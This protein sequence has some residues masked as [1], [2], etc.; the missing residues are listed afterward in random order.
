[1]V[2]YT[3]DIGGSTTMLIRDTGGNVEFWIKTGSQTWNNEQPWSFFANG[4]NSGTLYFRMLRG[5]NWQKFGEVH[6]SYDQDVRFTIFNAGLGFPTYDFWQH[7]SRS[8]VPGA[9][10]IHLTHAISSTYIQVGF[11]DGY[12]G[13]SPILE[14]RL[15]YGGNPNNLEA[16]WDAP[17]GLTNVGPFSPGSRVYFWAQERNAIGWSSWSNRTEAT[18]WRIPDAPA[19]I[20]FSDVTQTSVRTQFSDGFNGGT[21][22]LERELGYGEDPFNAEAFAND[23]S[24]I[25]VLTN[26][27]PGRTYY[28]WARTRNIVGWSAWSERR[29]INLIAG[30][31][32]FV[33][34]Q[35]VRAV[36]YVKVSGTWRVARPWVRNAGV[37]KETSV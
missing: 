29:Q 15:G 12:S 33:G 32:I 11:S 8:T 37:W 6:V 34:N 24:G 20:T 17:S 35:W 4:S 18:T 23:I 9:P 31:R 7:I 36:P 27:D 14:R 3:R 16:Y 2:D 10:Y 30:A 25:N 13:G 22:V 1:M 21:E 28:F 5:G 26:L 19:D